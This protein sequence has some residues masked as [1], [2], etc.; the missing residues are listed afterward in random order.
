M[1]PWSRGSQVVNG[2]KPLQDIQKLPSLKLK[3]FRSWKKRWVKLS[4][5][6]PDFQGAFAVS[7]R[8]GNNVGSWTLMG[9][10]FRSF[11]FCWAWSIFRGKKCKRFRECSKL[12][13]GD[14]WNIWKYDEISFIYWDV[15]K[16]TYMIYFR[17][18]THSS[19]N[20]LD[21]FTRL[22]L[23]GEMIQFDSWISDGLKLPASWNLD[24][25]NSKTHFAN[26]NVVKYHV[27]NFLSKTR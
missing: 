24:Q 18:K 4:S 21:Y 17:S 13:V 15:M 23:F 1:T 2:E 20:I 10:N 22:P 19:P 8:E 5:E 7:F 27:I 25:H 26:I 9:W 3:F 6:S 12:E 16:D 11:L 14:W